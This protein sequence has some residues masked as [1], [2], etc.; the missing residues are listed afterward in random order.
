M[1]GLTTETTLEFGFQS[2][3][4]G[5]LHLAEAT[6]NA[7]VSCTKNNSHSFVFIN[8]GYYF[9]HKTIYTQ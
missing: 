4:S 7:I 8:Q 1:S 2:D 5:H 3:Q 9:K 6:Y